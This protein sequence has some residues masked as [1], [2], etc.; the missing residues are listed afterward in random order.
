[1]A[2]TEAE[3]IREY[4]RKKIELGFKEVRFM[5]DK[6]TVQAISMLS[7][8]YGITQAEVVKR[9]ISLVSNGE[10]CEHSLV[11]NDGVLVSNGKDTQ[12]SNIKTDVVKQEAVKPL[13]SNDDQNNIYYINNIYTE[14]SKSYT[15][16]EGSEV[17]R[18]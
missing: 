6:E 14:Y 15:S 1:M 18:L 4:R 2:K 3:R 7:K 10:Y 9:G 12:V 17:L 13:V 8:K 16:T 5:L 11:S